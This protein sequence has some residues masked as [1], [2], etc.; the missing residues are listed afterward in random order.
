METKEIS[1]E[2]IKTLVKLGIDVNDLINIYHKVAKRGHD[3]SKEEYINNLTNMLKFFQSRNATLGEDDDVILKEDVLEMITKN[4]KLVSLDLEK[5]IK[6]I[7]DKLDSYYFMNKN[8]TNKL[9]KV[10]PNIFNVNKVDLE[11]YATLFSDFGINLDGEIV[12]LYE[13]VIKY[14]SDILKF[15]PQ[16]M[17]QRLMTV[18]DKMN[19]KLITQKEILDIQKIEFKVENK[20]KYILPKYEL[21]D[22]NEYKQ[23]VL[24]VMGN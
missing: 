16:T 9:I 17:F 13:Y 23:K 18:R 5:K 11:V 10:N 24:D 20:E 15:E 8:F 22:I 6:Y 7:C 21:G 19:S 1:E 12:N 3:I 4:T 14:N 2:N